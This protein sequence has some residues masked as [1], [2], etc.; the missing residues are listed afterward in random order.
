MT[1][2]LIT[3]VKAARRVSTPLIAIKTADSAATIAAV[4]SNIKDDVPKFR[5]DIINGLVALNDA[6]TMPLNQLIG[7]ADP[8]AAT[9]RPTDCLA[10]LPKLPEQSLCF[11]LQASRYME[12]PGSESVVQGIWNLRDL[13]KADRR[14]LILLSV[15]FNLP[16]ELAQDVL[17]FDEPLPN[18]N[19]LQQIVSDQFD[20]A[21][22]KAP[23]DD[24]LARSV[25]ALR[26]LAAFPAE[27]ITAMA[28]KQQTKDDPTGID[29]AALWERKQSMINATP[30]LSVWRGQETFADIGGVDN[31]KSFMRRY[32]EGK[33]PPRAI[34]F[35]DEIEKALAGAGGDT[36]GVSQNMLGTLLSYMQDNDATGTIYIGPPGAAKSMLAKAVGGE[37]GV[38]TISMDMGAMKASLVGES[39][40]RF[41]NAL[42]IISAV[43]DNRAL[44]IAT[45]NS[46]GV[47]PPE[48]RR[49][50][51][52]GTFFFDLPNA[53]DRK[54]IWALYLRKYGVDTNQDMPN[55]ADWTGAEI[56]Q[57]A[58]VA[59]LLS[60][61]L[62]E[63][64]TYV[65]PVARAAAESIEKLRREAH[66]RFIDAS[67]KGVYQYVKA[68][69]A[70]PGISAPAAQAARRA[71]GSALGKDSDA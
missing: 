31:A 55:D 62:V 8:V 50:F 20:A 58:H 45:C 11:F 30:G 19:E 36:S 65:V 61:S 27:Q 64:A 63:A 49:R 71:L 24:V 29:V 37:A 2:K 70:A 12:G 67:A 6:A 68:T 46:I 59:Y 33:E 60:I 38:P 10:L 56:R 34:V 32:I 18:A 51:K 23:S 7:D 52:L 28:L 53:D 48:L 57:C 13:F 5:W 15:E 22:L 69:A 3:N 16:A 9:G 21:S 4:C 44:F 42:K 40:Q 35:I 14:T 41:R 25:D 47:L 39:E 43:S 66:G 26:G 1:T 54:A 17:L